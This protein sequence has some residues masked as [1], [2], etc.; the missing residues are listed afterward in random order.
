MVTW[1]TMI[2]GNILLVN[3]KSAVRL[4]QI[5]QNEGMR[6]NEVTLAS[7]LAACTYLPDVRLG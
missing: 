2:N 5:M 3:W 6:P 7:L 4:C 1:T